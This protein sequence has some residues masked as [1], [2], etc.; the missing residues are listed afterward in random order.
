M[1]TIKAV[2][3]EDESKSIKVLKALLEMFHPEVEVV[4][5]ASSVTEASPLLASATF[6]L[7]FLD[8]NLSDGNGFEIIQPGD[9]QKFNI[10]FTTAHEKY[11]SK[12][13]HLNA[14]HYLL[15]P[16]DPEELN[17]SIERHKKSPLYIEKEE[18]PILQLGKLPLSTKDGLIL[19]EINEIIRIQSSDK[20]SVF[21]MSDKKQHIISKPLTK[22]ELLLKPFHFYRVHDRHLVNLKFAKS[23]NRSNGDLELADS[24]TIVVSQRKKEEIFKLFSSR[25]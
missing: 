20:Y 8:V 3:V 13:F 10:V 9:E 18:E 15:K 2:I 24:S 25:L 16:I 19:I 22:F 14:I 23:Y 1:K 5:T 11:A 6:E 7:L 12:A 4:A 21:H 17:I